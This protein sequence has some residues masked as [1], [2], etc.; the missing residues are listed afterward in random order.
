MMVFMEVT[1]QINNPFQ[2]DNW[3]RNGYEVKRDG[4]EFFAFKREELVEE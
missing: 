3:R 1:S 4:N 2:M